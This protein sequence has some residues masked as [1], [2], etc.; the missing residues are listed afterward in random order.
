MVL[1]SPVFVIGYVFSVLSLIASLYVMISYL[2]HKP[3]RHNAF[4]FL[5]A[6]INFLDLCLGFSSVPLLSIHITENDDVIADGVECSI[7]GVLRTFAL[8]SS[9]LMNVLLAWAIY[10]GVTLTSY[11]EAKPNSYYHVRVAGI[12]LCSLIAALLP[13]STNS[14][15]KGTLYCDLKADTQP[16]DLV[17]Q[18][19][20][21]IVPFILSFCC[22]VVMMVMAI[23]QLRKLYGGS[24]IKRRFYRLLLFPAIF[25]FVNSGGFISRFATFSSVIPEWLESY[26][27]LLRQIQGVFHGGVYGLIF[28]LD[29]S[30]SAQ[31]KTSYHESKELLIDTNSE[32]VLS[33]PINRL[34]DVNAESPRAS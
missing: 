27:F 28:L 34:S 8:L 10:C 12:Y 1:S 2:I 23:R 11:S 19:I 17:W 32:S 13:L 30:H 4:F 31:E 18:I 29:R 7:F 33:F 21:Y 6:S 15:G 16:A 5:I 25:L 3:T 22:I 20:D 9:Y 24:T 14:I 26:H